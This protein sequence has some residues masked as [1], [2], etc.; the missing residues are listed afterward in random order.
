MAVWSFPSC[1]YLF[2]GH[3]MLVSD[4]GNDREGKGLDEA[5]QRVWLV[6]YNSSSKRVC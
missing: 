2:S 4:D 6:P 1:I 3:H 5:L